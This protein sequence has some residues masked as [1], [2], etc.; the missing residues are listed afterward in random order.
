N[1]TCLLLSPLAL[2]IVFFYSYTKRFLWASQIALGLSLAIAPVGAWIAV[3]G[4]IAWP[5]VLLGGGV[6]HHLR[7]SG[8]RL[9]PPRRTSLDSR[10]LRRDDEPGNRPP[11]PRALRRRA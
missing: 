4:G 8:R 3:T 7:A 5:P 11:A 1:R 2:A 10:A 6:R 9:R